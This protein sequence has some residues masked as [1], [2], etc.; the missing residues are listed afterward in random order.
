MEK[1]KAFISDKEESLFG[2]KRSNKSFSLLKDG[3][4]CTSENL[5]FLEKE[6]I[7]KK[8]QK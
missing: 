8:P 3:E 4:N 2:I 6:L 7:F 1:V 5:E